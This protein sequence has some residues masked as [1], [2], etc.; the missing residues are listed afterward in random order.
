MSRVIIAARR[1]GRLRPVDEDDNTEALINGFACGA[2]IRALAIFCP[3]CGAAFEI[4][5][6]EVGSRIFDRRA[7]RFRC[8]RCRLSARVR[9]AMDIGFAADDAERDTGPHQH[10]TPRRVRDGA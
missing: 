8:S 5:A 6:G 2:E 3:G 4:R 9:A 7:Q 10:Q 1:S